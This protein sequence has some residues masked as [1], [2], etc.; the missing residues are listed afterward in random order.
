MKTTI[1][2]LLTTLASFQVQAT[3]LYETVIGKTLDPVQEVQSDAGEFTYTPLYEQVT[4]NKAN[5]NDE[6][7]GS[8]TEFTYTPLYNVV[9]GDQKAKANEI[10]NN[11][12][13]AEDGRS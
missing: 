10:A 9:V 4:A 3:G 7:Q 5:F 11:R 1:A 12:K 13:V 2:I 8:A 6:I